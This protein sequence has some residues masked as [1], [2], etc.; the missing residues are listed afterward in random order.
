MSL[1][2]GNHRIRLHRRICVLRVS[3]FGKGRE[4]PAFPRLIAAFP[5]SIPAFPRLIAAF[6]RSIPAFPRLIPAFARPVPAFPPVI[7]AFPRLIPAFP[8]IIP[9][10]P[11]V[12]CSLQSFRRSLHS[13]RRSLDPFWRSLDPFPCSLQSFRRSLHSFRRSLQSFRRSLDSFRRSLDSFRRSL[14]PFPLSPDRG[15]RPTFNGKWPFLAR[16]AHFPSYR[17][18]I[19]ERTCLR[20]C[21]DHLRPGAYCVSIAPPARNGV[22][23]ARARRNGVSARE[24]SPFSPRKPASRPGSA[25]TYFT[26]NTFVVSSPNWLTTRTASFWPFFT[27][28]GRLVWP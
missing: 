8:R 25:D 21:A 11:S 15:R 10:F 23:P 2:R 24:Q 28:N 14:D 26:D 18:S 20:D 27:G 17:N 3:S 13:F 7:P 4:K 9:V 22:A 19:A 1:N 12:P 16:N 6:P 5:R